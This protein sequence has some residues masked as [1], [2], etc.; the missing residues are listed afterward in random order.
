MIK[1]ALKMNV[2]PRVEIPNIEAAKPF[3]DMGVRHFSLSSDIA[4]LAG[5]YKQQ[6]VVLRKQLP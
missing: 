6:A 4:I 5:W 3:I 1:L 2:A